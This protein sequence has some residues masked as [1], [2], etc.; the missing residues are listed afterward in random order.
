[1]R[2][3]AFGQ[4]PDYLEALCDAL[5]RNG[6]S[7]GHQFDSEA[8]L[9]SQSRQLDDELVVM[10]V[11]RPGAQLLEAIRLLQLESPK[12]V[13]LFAEQTDEKVTDLVVK[14]SV[15]SFVVNGFDETR[16]KNIINTA[17]LRNQEMQ[18]IKDELIRA[19]LTLSER[20]QIERAKGVLMKQKAMDEEAAYKTMRQAAMS[21]NKRMI[22][23]ANNII[24][25]AEML[26]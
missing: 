24:D 18:T 26:N 2:T 22:D 14:A 9:L 10:L 1:M 11:K 13:V 5:K 15:A 8:S 21:Q 20:K 4:N 17:V 16:I 3:T 23:V 12:T 7:I 25:V 19:K 6:F